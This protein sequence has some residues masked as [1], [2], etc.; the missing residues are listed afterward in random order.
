MS[1]QIVVEGTPVAKGRP[2]FSIIAGHVNAYT[3]KKTRD[4]EARISQAARIA[5]IGF[6]TGFEG[7]LAVKI[8]VTLIPPVSWSKKKRLA[9]VTDA[10]RP[11][12]RPDVD[13]YAK[14]A[15]DACNK[16][17]FRDDSQITDLIITKR[18]GHSASLVIIVDS[19][20]RIREAAII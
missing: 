4:Y 16:I 3:D 5:M 15:I 19:V 1:I 17:V 18:Y 11:V 6:Q 8:M 12:T 13:N 7:A 9:A 2:R 14:A 10:I 20:D